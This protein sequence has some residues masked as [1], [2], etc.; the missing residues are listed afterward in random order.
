MTRAEKVAQAQALRAEGLKLREIAERMGMALQTVHAYLT[1]PDGSKVRA[2]KESYRGTCV[3]CGRRTDGSN[4][5][6]RAPERCNPCAAATLS[7]RRAHSESNVGKVAWTDEEMLQALRDL[8][9]GRA[10]TADEVDAASQ[11]PSKAIVGRRFGSWNNA[12]RAAGLTPNRPDHKQHYD[13][14]RWKPEE[15][16][17]AVAAL[18][19]EH[20]LEIDD[21]A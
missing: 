4:G 3:D 6:A 10:P 15:C 12:L 9:N 18:T 16:L 21:A 19:L 8:G 17:E 7:V 20:P 2:R 11:A 5:T 14:L 1:D 13:R